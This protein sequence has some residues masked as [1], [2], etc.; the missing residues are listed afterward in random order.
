[1][2]QLSCL[3]R[4]HIGIRKSENQLKNILIDKL[5]LTD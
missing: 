1:M 5:N 2:S 3:N 4:L